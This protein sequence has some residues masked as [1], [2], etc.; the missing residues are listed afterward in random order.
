[1][2]LGPK[3]IIPVLEIV[4]A[5]F[6]MHRW[7]AKRAEDFALSAPAAGPLIFWVGL[8]AAWMLASNFAWHWRGPWDFSVWKRASLFQDA[9]RVLAVGVLGPVGEE[10]IFR[11]FFYRVIER[12]SAGW[13]MAVIVT[14]AAWACLHIQES[15]GVILL[16]PREW[17]A[18][19]AGATPS[20]IGLG[21]SC[22]AYYLESVFRLVG[23]T[24]PGVWSARSIPPFGYLPLRSDVGIVRKRMPWMLIHP[25]HHR[26]VERRSDGRHRDLF[27]SRLNLANVHVL[28]TF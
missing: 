12:T 19:W 6:A 10:L 22:H 20:E 18:A 1:M 17:I 11:G 7:K 21:A 25:V 26:Y 16:F 4:A 24:I 3:I 5:L 15:W 2:T 14:A 9:G 8:F 23:I 13:T 27:E 28:V